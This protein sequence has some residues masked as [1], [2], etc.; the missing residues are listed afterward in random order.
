M[1]TEETDVLQA[2]IDALEKS[3]ATLRAYICRKECPYGWTN[4]ETGICQIGIPGCACEDDVYT[5][6]SVRMEPMINALLEALNGTPGWQKKAKEVLSPYV[7][8]DGEP[9]MEEPQM[10]K[11]ESK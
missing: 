5:W 4:P 3:E 7:P 1:T 10:T 2:R 6:E 8:F 11:E 9:T